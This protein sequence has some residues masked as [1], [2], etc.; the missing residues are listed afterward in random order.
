MLFGAFSI[1]AFCGIAIHIYVAYIPSA[2]LVPLNFC[3]SVCLSACL[4]VSFKAKARP[5][6]RA[7]SSQNLN[8]GLSLPLSSAFLPCWAFGQRRVCNIEM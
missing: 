2:L 4:P 5:H 6:C 3:L 1:H 8:H 7:R